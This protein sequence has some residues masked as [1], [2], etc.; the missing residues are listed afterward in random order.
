[1]TI[2]QSPRGSRKRED[3][4]PAC[5]CFNLRKAA[6]AVTQ[7]Y[8]EALQSSGLRGTQFSLLA[9]LN[10]MGSATVSDLARAMVM[11]RTTL[12]RNLR[13]LEKQGWIEIVPGKDRRTRQ[14][15]LTSSGRKTLKQ[16]MPLWKK[17]QKQMVTLLGRQRWTGL[18]DHLDHTIQKV[19]GL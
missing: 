3:Q 13:P 10:H 15:A 1:M 8:D 4:V 17:A 11:D 5:T 16:A 9:A 12:T 7:L 2:S 14:L 6:R 19:G 18:L